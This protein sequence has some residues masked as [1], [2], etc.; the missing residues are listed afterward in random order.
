[1]DITLFELAD[2]KTHSFKT[3]K[4][5]KLLKQ[6]ES[7]FGEDTLAFNNL[8]FRPIITN[9]KLHQYYYLNKTFHQWPIKRIQKAYSQAKSGIAFQTFNADSSL[10]YLKD[11]ITKDDPVFSIAMSMN[12]HSIYPE[13]I[14]SDYSFSILKVVSK[15]A[16]GIIIET[17]S[18]LKNDIQPWLKEEVQKLDIK[19]YDENLY[20]QLRTDYPDLY[21][22]KSLIL[23][24]NQASPT[25]N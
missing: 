8:Y 6:I 25:Q 17:I 22:V 5:P 2:L 19:M 14:E 24:K 7:I 11:T 13:I 18:T 12:E 1:M 9:Q 4:A 20:Q 23:V 15:T 16:E 21:W 10:Q 3:S